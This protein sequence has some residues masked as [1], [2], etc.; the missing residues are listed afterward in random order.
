M[1]SVSPISF[2]ATLMRQ[3]KPTREGRHETTHDEFLRS[4]DDQIQ[5]I[6]DYKNFAE[7][8]DTLMYSDSDIQDA[9]KKLPDDMEIELAANFATDDSYDETKVKPSSPM[10]IADGA[11]LSG[12]SIICKYDEKGPDKESIMDWLSQIAKLAN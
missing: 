12:E 3:T 9:I 6:S 4:Y 1:L 8:L 7:Q 5:K 10:I 11:G 2:K